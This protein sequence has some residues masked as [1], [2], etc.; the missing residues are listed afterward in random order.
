MTLG[1]GYKVSRTEKSGAASKTLNGSYS[2]LFAL[3]INYFTFFDFMHMWSCETEVMA[4]SKVGLRAG[5]TGAV[6]HLLQHHWFHNLLWHNGGRFFSKYTRHAPRDVT[7]VMNYM[8]FLGHTK[9][10]GND[11][12]TRND[13][14]P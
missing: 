6:S 8:T 3:N 7:F 9:T 1:S 5:S 13:E 14:R 11:K 4:L 10:R 12:L 2:I